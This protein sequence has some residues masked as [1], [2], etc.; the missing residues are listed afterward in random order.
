MKTKYYKPLPENLT[1]QKSE[2]H[3]LGLFALEKILKE[4]D[5]GISHIFHVDF[6]DEYIRTPLGGFVNYSETPNCE[7]KINVDGYNLV[8]LHDIEKGEE[9]TL[10]YNL[11]NPTDE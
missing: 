8:T 10:K 1:I 7:I 5:L 6:E 4:T 3:G 9:L 2:V 11:Y